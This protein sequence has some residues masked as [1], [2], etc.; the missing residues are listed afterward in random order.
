MEKKKQNSC[1]AYSNQIAL[2]FV[3]V[4]IMVVYHL[5]LSLL[6]SKIVWGVG[7]IIGYFTLLIVSYRLVPSQQATEKK[8]RIYH[9]LWYLV[10]TLWT[11]VVLAWGFKL[12]ACQLTSENPGLLCIV[13][14]LI[15]ASILAFVGMLAQSS[16]HGQD[17]NTKSSKDH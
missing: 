3:S 11:I 10:M 6:P 16:A 4:L 13:T 8:W 5:L 9:R 7:L 2:F 15:G 1:S 14:I 12:G 17:G